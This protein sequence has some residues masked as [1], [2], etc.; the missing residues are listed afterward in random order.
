PIWI[1]LADCIAAK[2]LGGKSPEIIEAIGFNPK[3]RQSRLHNINIGGNDNYSIN[4]AKDD[5]YK[6]LIEMRHEIKSEMAGAQSIE[7]GQLD[8]AQHNL[9][10][11]ANSTSY[12]IFVEIN[13][14]DASRG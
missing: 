5:F 8:T 1:T 4:P 3:R 10:I 14:S 7:R 9:K 6:R 13:V 12:G 11:L 2:L